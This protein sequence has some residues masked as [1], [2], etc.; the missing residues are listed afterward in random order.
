M[1]L[2]CRDWVIGFSLLVVATGCTPEA[3]TASAQPA[4]AA[5]LLESDLAVLPNNV[6]IQSSRN[7][8]LALRDG[9]EVAWELA[10]PNDDRVIAPVAVALNSVT[11]VRGAK[12]I[13]AATPDGKWL[14]S[15]Q[16]DGEATGRSTVT[17]TPVALSDSAVALMIGDDLVRFD[18]N[19]GVRWRVTLPEGRLTSRIVGGMDGS[20]LV[21]TTT[22]LYSFNPEGNVT[23]HR[24]LQGR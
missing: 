22:G 20:V 11:Y 10:L 3:S 4:P 19:G 15:K 24:A 21:P 9:G 8:L 5:S 18:T 16:L 14:W 2:G 1:M 23:W 12:F 7:K 17:N 13:H 6:V